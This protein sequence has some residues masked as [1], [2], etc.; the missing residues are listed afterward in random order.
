MFAVRFLPISLFV[1]VALATV[2]LPGCASDCT[3]ANPEL[4]RRLEGEWALAEMRNTG[5]SNP[6]LDF[7]AGTISTLTS[8]LRTHYVFQLDGVCRTRIWNPVTSQ[9]V[10]GDNGSWKIAE[11]GNTIEMT[12]GPSARVERY[13]VETRDNEVLLLPANSQDAIAMVLARPESLPEPG[14]DA[15]RQRIAGQAGRAGRGAAESLDTL[16]D[17]MQDGL[18]ALRGGL[19]TFADSVNAG[20]QDAANRRQQE[21]AAREEAERQ[22]RQQEQAAREEA[23]RQRRQQEEA[24]RQRREQQ[25]QNNNGGRREG[26]G[27]GG[28]GRREGG[29]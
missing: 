27:G 9:M 24:E 18:D 6:I 15:D 19:E 3:R 2:L 21:Q 12:I 22:R 14:S 29:Q 5:P 20:L 16:V 8:G 26:S 23:E 11:D 10:D 25:N 17:V 13:R 1:A 28:G 7:A 4:G